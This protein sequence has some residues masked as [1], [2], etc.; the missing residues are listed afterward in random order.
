M[1]R[2]NRK[3]SAVWLTNQ[4]VCR[5]IPHNCEPTKTL[6]SLAHAANSGAFENDGSDFRSD[7]LPLS[8][9]NFKENV[10]DIQARLPVT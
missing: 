4:F 6:D 9:Q 7:K 8:L 2:G 3:V 10:L 5:D 1:S